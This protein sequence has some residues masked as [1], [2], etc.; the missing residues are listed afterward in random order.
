MSDGYPIFQDGVGGVYK[1]EKAINHTSK[2]IRNIKKK[3]VE[4]L[5]YFITTDNLGSVKEDELIK[6][7]KAMYG[8]AASFIDPKN[9]NEVTKTLNKLFLIKNMI[10]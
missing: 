5:S 8:K 6:D 7:F 2:I 10:S 1:G 9:L 3:G 4:V